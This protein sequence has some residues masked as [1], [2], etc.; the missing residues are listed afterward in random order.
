MVT[1]KRIIKSKA[2]KVFKEMQLGDVQKTF[3][4]TKSIKSNINIKP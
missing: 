3:A 1:R 2:I 4:D